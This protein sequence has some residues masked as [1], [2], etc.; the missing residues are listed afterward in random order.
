MDESPT[1]EQAPPEPCIA[2]HGTG[3]VLSNIGGTAH[4]VSCPWCD[5]GGIYLRGHDAQALW[6]EGD[7]STSV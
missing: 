3:R 5:G 2:C 7:S 1:D 4:Q 6:R